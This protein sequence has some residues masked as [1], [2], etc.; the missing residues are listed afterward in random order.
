MF[1]SFAPPGPLLSGPD[2][3]CGALGL[4]KLCL[5]AAKAR[6][7]PFNPRV[8]YVAWE[9]IS[10]SD[11]IWLAQSACYLDLPVDVSKLSK[12]GELQY[13]YQLIQFSLGDSYTFISQIICGQP[14]SL[15]TLNGEWQAYCVHNRESK[16]DASARI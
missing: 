9:T 1:R 15:A 13:S 10:Q 7:R 12:T 2:N 14:R 5:F 8:L 3:E 11:L 4:S 6:R 16:Q